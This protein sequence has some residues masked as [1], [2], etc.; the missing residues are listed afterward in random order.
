MARNYPEKV[1]ND[2]IN[3]VVFGKNPPVKKSSENGIPFVATS[4]TKVKDLGK[5]V[6]DLL[7]FLYSDEEV[8]K[9]LSPPPISSYRSAG[10]MKD[11]I[12][13][14]NSVFLGA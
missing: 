4:H 12:L 6:K 13:S 10:K 1:V 8:E 7:P 11:Y 9:V 3:K 14:C 5:L 2:Q